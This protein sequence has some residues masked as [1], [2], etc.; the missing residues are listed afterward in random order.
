MSTLE[1]SNDPL[2]FEEDRR[3]PGLFDRFP[4]KLCSYSVRYLK[5]LKSEFIFLVLHGFNFY[6]E[7][8]VF[9]KRQCYGE[10]WT[11]PKRSDRKLEKII[12]VLSHIVKQSSHY[13]FIGSLVRISSRRLLCWLTFFAFVINYGIIP[14]NTSR[15]FPFSPFRIHQDNN[16]MLYSLCIWTFSYQESVSQQR[17]VWFMRTRCL[18][19]INSL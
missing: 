17:F 5:N 7:F 8:R 9:E 14:P 11:W 6:V 3:F 12:A 10:Y 16:L 15:T 2:C 1:H 19:T 13:V 4:R 18:C